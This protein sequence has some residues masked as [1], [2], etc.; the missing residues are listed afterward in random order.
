MTRIMLYTSFTLTASL[1][2]REY[3]PDF[4]DEK[5]RLRE[6]KKP[7]QVT[8]L[9]GGRERCEAFSY[10]SWPGPTSL[11]RSLFTPDP[12]F[13]PSLHAGPHR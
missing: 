11:P 1:K 8:Q 2:V 13:C 7:A 9:M 12:H 5:L 3:F 10:L 6:A 4:I